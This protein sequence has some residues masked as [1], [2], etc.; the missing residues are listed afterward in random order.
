MKIIL[1]TLLM[2]M[3]NESVIGQVCHFD[4]QCSPGEVCL[5]DS[6]GSQTGKCVKI[7]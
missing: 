7:N 1:I 6:A 4:S 3:S 2:A 5:I